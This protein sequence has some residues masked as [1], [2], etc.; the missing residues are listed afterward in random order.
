MDNAK[1]WAVV[2]DAI[3]RAPPPACHSAVRAYAQLDERQTSFATCIDAGFCIVTHTR[4]AAAK[5]QRRLRSRL[6]RGR[7]LFRARGLVAA[8]GNFAPHGYC[9]G[10][11][12]LE[13][14]LARFRF[15]YN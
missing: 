12:L 4:D 7:L 10:P 11:V 2:R 14:R 15:A 9:P 1:D 3:G 6:L 5:L 8:F 13:S